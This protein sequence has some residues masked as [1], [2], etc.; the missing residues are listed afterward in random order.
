MKS[1]TKMISP[2]DL[3]SKEEVVKKNELGRGSYYSSD[4]TRDSI[5]DDVE[6]TGDDNTTDLGGTVDRAHIIDQ[7]VDGPIAGT[8]GHPGID[9][10]TG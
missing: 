5:P 6:V 4:L 8:P 9:E 3:E 10:D 2:I 1:D 7:D